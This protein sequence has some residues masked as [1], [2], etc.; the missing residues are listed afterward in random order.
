MFLLLSD[1]LTIKQT[2]DPTYPVWF[3][4]FL[5]SVLVTYTSS[6]TADRSIHIVCLMLVAAAGNAIA[7]STTSVGP[8]FLAMFMM[9]MGA[10]SAYQIIVAWVANSFPRP[11]VK[12]SAAI[13]VCN[14]IG[15][16]ASIYGSY[17]YPKSAAPQYVP[18]GSANAVVSLL[19]AAMALVLR[20][21]HVRENKKLAARESGEVTEEGGVGSRAAG[22]RYVY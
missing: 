1:C 19:V 17:M 21:I 15:N 22:F 11:L 18:G 8:R 2:T 14:M 7:T 16:T 10:V 6:K 20:W 4:T 12:R 5:V 9:P 3:A 13:A